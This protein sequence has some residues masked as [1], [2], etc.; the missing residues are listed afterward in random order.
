MKMSVNNSRTSRRVLDPRLAHRMED[1]ALHD[2]VPH[3]ARPLAVEEALAVKE[4]KAVRA[5]HYARVPPMGFADVSGVGRTRLAEVCRHGLRPLPV[6]HLELIRRHEEEEEL[7]REALAAQ[8]CCFHHRAD[9]ERRECL[10]QRTAA[11]THPRAVARVC[12]SWTLF[13]GAPSR[14]RRTPPR[15]RVVRVL[16]ELHRDRIGT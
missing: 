16:Y 14:S 12:A 1:L 4:D 3:Y 2:V 5:K 9:A 7:A 8:K 11:H 13:I 10:P 6:R 15:R